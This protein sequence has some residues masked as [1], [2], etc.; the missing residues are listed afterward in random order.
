MTNQRWRRCWQQTLA[1][2]AGNADKQTLT[3]MNYSKWDTIDTDSDDDEDDIGQ[4]LGHKA[5]RLKREAHVVFTA[6]EQADTAASSNDTV[7]KLAAAAKF[8]ASARM[9]GEALHIL[10]AYEAKV[11]AVLTMNKKN[12][13]MAKQAKKHISTERLSC[14]MNSGVAYS[15]LRQWDKCIYACSES[16]KIDPDHAKAYEVRGYAYKG[17]GDRESSKKDFYGA[18]EISDS[19]KEAKK[20]LMGILGD[21]KNA[22]LTTLYERAKEHSRAGNSKAAAESY[23]ALL[24]KMPPPSQRTAR[25]KQLWFHSHYCAGACHSAIA[26]GNVDK[27]IDHLEACLGWPQKGKA[28]TETIDWKNNTQAA[29]VVL[30]ALDRLVKSHRAKFNSFGFNL[31]LPSIVKYAENMLQALEDAKCIG[32]LNDVTKGTSDQVW[33]GG[34]GRFM[35]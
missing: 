34:G 4:E 25:Q 24:A 5:E 30:D 19:C 3:A 18:V 17:K 29:E 7:A 21:E 1:T 26:E 32:A 23:E 31:S 27:I 12:Q 9:Y 28:S 14:F 13:D 8:E 20:E 22:E 16:L 15:R 10:D 33:G 6:A 35:E 11:T 2:L